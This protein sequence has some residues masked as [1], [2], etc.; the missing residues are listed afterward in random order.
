MAF[1]SVLTVF[2]SFKYVKVRFISTLK[3]CEFKLFHFK[4]CT[5][6]HVIHPI[7]FKVTLFIEILL[8]LI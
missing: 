1:I 2:Q 4:H 8:L 7:K 5:D 6:I 3:G